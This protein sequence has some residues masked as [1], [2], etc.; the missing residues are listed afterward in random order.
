MF[1]PTKLGPTHINLKHPFAI[2]SSSDHR[3]SELIKNG[4]SNHRHRRRLDRPPP[5]L[6]LRMK[7]NNQHESLFFR[8]NVNRSNQILNYLSLKELSIFGQTCKKA[9]YLVQQF[10]RELQ[11]CIDNEYG[12]QIF[13]HLT[14]RH[15]IVLQTTSPEDFLF[16]FPPFREIRKL[17]LNFDGYECG[18]INLVHLPCLTHLKLRG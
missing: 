11:I 14:Y 18:K 10:V 15:H 4:S 16:P 13:N 2:R 1:T 17:F 8:L 12:A 6:S 9:N 3:P 5:P 7:P